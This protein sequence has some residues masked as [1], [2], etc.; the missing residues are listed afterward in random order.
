MAIFLEQIRVQNANTGDILRVEGN[1]IVPMDTT[2]TKQASLV[3]GDNITLEANGLISASFS[4]TTSDVIEKDVL[5][6]TDERVHANVA[7]LALSTFRDDV[8]YATRFD[9]D[10]ALARLDTTKV[11]EGDNLY[12]TDARVKAYLDQNIAPYTDDQVGRYISEN[13]S[14]TDITEGDNLYYTD[15]R[16]RKAF[17]AGDKISISGDGVI[18][19]EATGSGLF[20]TD[21]DGSVGY[22][23]TNSLDVA[24]AFDT[25]AIIHS[26][27]LTNTS[28]DKDKTASAKVVLTI[29]PKLSESIIENINLAYGSCAEIL[30][31]PQVVKKGDKIKM[32]GFLDGVATGGAVHATVIYETVESGKYERAADTVTWKEQSTVY[33]STGKASILESI[34]AVNIDDAKKT[35]AVTVTW[36]SPEGML[37]G[38]VCKDF[39]IPANSTVEFCERPFRLAPGD[40]LDASASHAD[41]IAL[42]VSA[43]RK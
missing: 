43:I 8:G 19:A 9:L 29:S 40:T 42:F 38:Y 18:T 25:D 2:E 7:K 20:N 28:D 36:K 30:V 24:V 17:T 13:I 16:A 31:K 41:A 26:I 37:K 21:I 32:Q 4:I 1:Q 11:P 34:K 5:Y 12:Y 14:T 22:G 3:A 35:H 15:A 39:V 6:Y 10:R 33:T 23:L 27:H